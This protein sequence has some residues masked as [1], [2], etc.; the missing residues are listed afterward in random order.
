MDLFGTLI[1]SLDPR[2][3]NSIAADANKQYVCN[4]INASGVSHKEPAEIPDSWGITAS[5][6]PSKLDEIANDY[7]QYRID[8]ST[9][10]L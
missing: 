3:L 1:Q 8:K 10:K 4:L 6:L 5:T 7:I 9:G 2:T